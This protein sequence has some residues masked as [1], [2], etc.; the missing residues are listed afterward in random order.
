MD[1]FKSDMR[2][3]FKYIITHEMPPSEGDIR[4]ASVIL[5]KWLVDRQLTQMCN[6]MEINPTL[7]GFNNDLALT[8]LSRRPDI[9]YFLSG[10]IKFMG[11]PVFGIYHSDLDW[12]V[13]PFIGIDDFQESFFTPNELLNQK[14]VVFQNQT[15]NASD[16][17]QFMANKHGG[18]HIN[19]N[20]TDKWQAMN[21][22][23]KFMT[24]GG[25]LEKISWGTPADI[26]LPFEENGEECLNGFHIEIIAI[27]SALLN[28]HFDGEM[29]L[30]LASKQ[31]VQEI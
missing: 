25:D 6:S 18:A 29:F 11:T 14:R 16:V 24:F 23:A 17:I 3:L 2:T 9:Y 28:I 20:L 30:I 1:I 4:M 12:P 15:F 22:A 26:H 21:R 13:E 7:H 19:L 5:R 8:K 27:A 31:N 10:G